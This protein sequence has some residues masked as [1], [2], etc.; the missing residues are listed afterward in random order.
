MKWKVSLALAAGAWLFAFGA[1]AQ[2]DSDAGNVQRVYFVHANPGEGK[3]LEDGWKAYMKCYGENGGKQEMH[4]WWRETGRLGTYAFVT[5]GHKW[6]DW[7]EME[8]ADKACDDVF[9]QQFL[10]HVGKATSTF[11]TYMTDASYMRDSDEPFKVAHV[12]DFKVSD[13]R[14]FVDNIMKVTEAAKAT[15]WDNDYVWFS[16]D[17]G[18][19][20]AADFYVVVLGHSFADWDKDRTGLWD[21]VA[22]H[23]GKEGADMIRSDLNAAIDD[24]WSDIYSHRS[25]LDYMPKQ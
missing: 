15:K 3:A 23:A 22:K 13:S 19:P 20:H 18:G 8:E 21:M 4:V 16:V 14:K 10:P 24:E 2:D 11:S 9:R 5:G 25:D 17:A 12:Y 1:W 7:D 6:G